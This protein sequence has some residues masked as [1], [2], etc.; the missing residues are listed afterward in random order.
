[1]SDVEISK[2]ASKAIRKILRQISQL[3]RQI[4]DILGAQMEE[5]D[6]TPDWRFD[7]TSGKFLAPE[8]K[9]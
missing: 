1:M 5:L 6:L 2:D 7:P 9:K 3:Q 4:G 8:V